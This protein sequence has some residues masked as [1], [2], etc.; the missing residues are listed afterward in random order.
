MDINDPDARTV[1]RLRATK[2]LDLDEVL[3]Q[4]VIKTH[5]SLTRITLEQTGA[6]RRGQR[7]PRRRAG[8]L[9]REALFTDDFKL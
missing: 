9:L 3:R 6:Q 8:L 7:P 1:Q 4:D 5:V 2:R